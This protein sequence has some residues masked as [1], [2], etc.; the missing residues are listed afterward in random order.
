MN[1]ELSEQDIYNLFDTNS[2]LYS[3]VIGQFRYLKDMRPGWQII[4]ECKEDPNWMNSHKYPTEE[5]RNIFKDKL[6]KIYINLYQHKADRAESE[7][8]WWMFAYGFQYEQN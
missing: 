1:E 8:G 3:L 4:K 2:L 7:A 6:E 5:S